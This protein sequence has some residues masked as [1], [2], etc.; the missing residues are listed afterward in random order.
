MQSWLKQG[1]KNPQ[2]N[3]VLKDLSSTLLECNAT[4]SLQ[5]LSSSGNPADFPSRKLSDKDCMLSKSA[6]LKVES[7]FGPHT[8]DMMALDSNV[9][10]NLLRHFIPHPTP[11]SAGVNVFAQVI[12][13]EENAYVFPPFVLVGP[14][15]KFLEI[16]PVNFTI[17]APRLYPLPFWWPVLRSRASSCSLVGSKGDFDVLLFPSPDNMFVPRPLQWDLFAFRVN[18]NVS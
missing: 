18:C 6:W 9:S 15:L 17:I 3:D 8:L 10:G 14:L 2:L 11:L 4:L 5:F 16:S 13:R 7:F 12:S 1:G